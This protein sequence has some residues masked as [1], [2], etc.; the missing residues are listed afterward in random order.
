MVAGSVECEVCRSRV[1]LAPVVSLSRM[2]KQFHMY[3]LTNPG[4]T[5]IIVFKRHRPK[6][7]QATAG[8]QTVGTTSSTM[9]G[10]GPAKLLVLI[11]TFPF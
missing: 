2:Q 3:F 5:V 4:G 10:A 1:I 9:A 6:H 11:N 7:K 8:V